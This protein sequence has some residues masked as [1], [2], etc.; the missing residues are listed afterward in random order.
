MNQTMNPRSST[1]LCS[2]HLPPEIRQDFL[3]KEA[4]FEI[5]YTPEGVKFVMWWDQAR[6]HEKQAVLRRAHER[7]VHVME[8]IKSFDHEIP[9]LG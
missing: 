9:E 8:A 3:V 4:N 6:N 1:V 7:D 5:P 2:L